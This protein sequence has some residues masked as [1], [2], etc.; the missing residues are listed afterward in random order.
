MLYRLICLS[1]I[2][3]LLHFSDASTPADYAKYKNIMPIPGRHQWPDRDGY[4]GSASIQMNALSFG[5]WLSQDVVRKA[6]TV[7]KC[8]HGGDG[9]EI[10][11]NNVLCALKTLKFEAEQ[12]DYHNEA[13]PQNKNY[14]LWMKKHLIQSHPIVMFIFCKGDSHRSHGGEQGYGNY[15]HIEPVVGILSNHSFAENADTFYE[16][17]IIVHHSDW[18][19]DSYYRSF[20]S[21]PD[22]T[23]MEGNCKDVI[24]IG[25]GPNEAYPCIPKD[26]DYGVAMI[27]H[28]DPL[29]V[30]TKVQIS[31]DNWKEPDTVEGNAPSEVTATITIKGKP[32][33]D[34]ILYRFDGFETV[35]T[36]SQ[37]HLAPYTYAKPYVTGS[38]GSLV[39]KD[40]MPFKSNTSVYYFAVPL[41]T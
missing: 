9:N 7:G 12:W 29:G 33:D 15:D 11:H 22:D 38:T 24:P 30:T 27:G 14:M 20:K 4:C 2:G 17:D 32:F 40:P 16:D 21:L 1:V 8:Q 34:G 6:I 13:I 37:F 36:D 10:L 39:Q 19:Q 18:S 5:T 25:G 35:P 28:V 3:T 23:K 41:S 31:V 26:I